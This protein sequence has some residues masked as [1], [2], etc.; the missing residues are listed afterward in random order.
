MQ[1]Q[2]KINE[3]SIL[4]SR[5]STRG[6]QPEIYNISDIRGID[7]ENKNKTVF[8]DRGLNIETANNLNKSTKMKNTQE[9]TKSSSRPAISEFIEENK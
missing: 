8:S 7:I 2:K 5:G 1:D 9:K 6:H 4:M 3:D